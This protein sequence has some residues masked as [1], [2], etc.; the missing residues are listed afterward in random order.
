M[1]IFSFSIV[2]CGGILFFMRLIGLTGNADKWMAFVESG[3][4]IYLGGPTAAALAKVLLQTMPD[5]IAVGLEHTLRE[6]RIYN[7]MAI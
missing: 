5:T 7:K 1:N 6:V 2:A 4:M 3:L